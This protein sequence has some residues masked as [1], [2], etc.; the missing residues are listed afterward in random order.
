MINGLHLR[1]DDE[2]IQEI[3]ILKKTNHENIIEYVGFFTE[4]MRICI[5]T[6]FYKVKRFYKKK[7]V[8]I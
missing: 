7:I 8:F 6:R 1:D 3:E 4:N 5:L 2:Q